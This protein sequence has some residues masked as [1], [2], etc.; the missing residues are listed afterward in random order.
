MEKIKVYLLMPVLVFSIAVSSGQELISSASNQATLDGYHVSWSLGETVTETMSSDYL[1][2]NQGFHQG[3]FEITTV[4]ETQSN[5][6]MLDVYPN[7]TTQY[8]HF[9]K[10]E[11]TEPVRFFLYDLSGKLIKTGLIAE[12]DFTWDL[13]ALKASSFILRIHSNNGELIKSFQIVKTK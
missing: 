5:D 11:N 13:R 9:R 2:L 12:G 3:F 8:L 6:I 10:T 7:P 1:I 4:F